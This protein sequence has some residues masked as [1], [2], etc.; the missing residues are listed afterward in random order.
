MGVNV[1]LFVVVQVGLEP[2]R[3][4]RLVRG[5]EEKVKEVV[6]QIPQQTT[7]QII[8]QVDVEQVQTVQTQE[9]TNSIAIDDVQND[10]GVGEV[11]LVGQDV[12]GEE[13]KIVDETE[14]DGAYII[15][16][17]DIWIGAAS[18]AVLGSILTALATYLI[19]R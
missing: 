3:R 4:G 13:L 2:W 10:E 11:L 8:Q 16:K 5:F 1:L 18:G 17:K 9:D 6:G 14:D 19:S 15:E 7:Q 12:D